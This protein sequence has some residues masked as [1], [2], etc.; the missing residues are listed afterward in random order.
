MAVN[1]SCPECGERLACLDDPQH[2][3]CFGCGGGFFY[4]DAPYRVEKL[5]PRQWLDEDIRLFSLAQDPTTRR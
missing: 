3:Y 1:R 2:L 5:T 4:G